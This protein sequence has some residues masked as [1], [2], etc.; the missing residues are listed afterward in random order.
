[1]SFL[2]WHWPTSLCI[3]WKVIYNFLF[4]S[5]VASDHNKTNTCVQ[6]ITQIRIEVFIRNRIYVRWQR[7][8]VIMVACL[9]MSLEEEE[10][11]CG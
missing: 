11:L 10:E 4:N 7:P 9:M 3:F 6:D 8:C 1:M 5:S 2:T